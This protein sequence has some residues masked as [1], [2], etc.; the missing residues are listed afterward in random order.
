[1]TGTIGRFTY[2]IIAPR[3][4]DMPFNAIVQVGPKMWSTDEDD[5]P[6]LSPNLMTEAEID[7]HINALKADLDKVGRLAK[8]ALKRANEK[9]MALVSARKANNSN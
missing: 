1:M 2:K 5:W 9:T 6:I 3:K 8:K 4:E 7:H